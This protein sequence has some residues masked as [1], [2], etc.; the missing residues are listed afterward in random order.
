MTSAVRLFRV[1]SNSAFGAVSSASLRFSGVTLRSSSVIAAVRL[2]VAAV[3]HS[4]HSSAPRSVSPRDVSE[5]LEADNVRKLIDDLKSTGR[6]QVPLE[7]FM[8][9][10]EAHGIK[11]DNAKKE[12]LKNLH[13]TGSILHFPET[14]EEHLRS[15]VLLRP[16]EVIEDFLTV[17]DVSGERARS[18]LENAFRSL[19]EINSEISRMQ[20]TKDVLDTRARRHAN[21]TL[22]GGFIFVVSQWLLLARLT[23]W[24][25]SW[26]RS[27][28]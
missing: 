12:T 19:E 21:L 6:R 26:V 8:R 4:F 20:T 9:K 24:E 23:W 27:A 28:I 7:E 5:A 15:T 18:M 11:D 14:Q 1:L 16:E 22:S 17:L 13:K 3:S 10:C 2:P 25:F